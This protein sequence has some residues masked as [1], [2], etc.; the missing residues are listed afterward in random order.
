MVE[1][2]RVVAYARA[3]NVDCCTSTTSALLEGVD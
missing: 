3:T 1:V 2:G